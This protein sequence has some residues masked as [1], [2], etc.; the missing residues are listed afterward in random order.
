MSYDRQG[1]RDPRLNRA[2]HIFPLSTTCN[3][4]VSRV[5]S[6]TSIKADVLVLERLEELSDRNFQAP[7]MAFQFVEGGFRHVVLA[8][9]TGRLRPA[10]CSRG[11][12][13]ICSI[14]YCEHFIVR[15]DKAE[16][17]TP[18]GK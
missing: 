5:R 18:N 3:I 11:I 13:T 6:V 15:R 4:V 1:D 9:Q 10:S 16:S 8:A 2:R 12:P 17:L 7:Y 14:V